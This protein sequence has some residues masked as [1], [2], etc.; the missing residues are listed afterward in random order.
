MVALCGPSGGG[1][2]TVVS[3]LL[4]FYRP[5]NGSIVVDGAVRRQ[6]VRER[7]SQMRAGVPL[8]SLNASE[9]RRHF[10]VVSQEPTLF[11]SSIAD[12]IAY[13][14]QNA[15]DDEIIAAAK[16]ANAHD[17]IMSFDQGYETLVGERGIKLV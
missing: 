12:N 8:D 7:H 11:A 6:R 14:A 15:S 10:A 13:G 4:A 1:K 17:F 3:L 16:V 2:S 5:Q 9:Y